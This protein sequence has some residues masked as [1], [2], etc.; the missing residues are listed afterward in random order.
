MVNVDTRRRIALLVVATGTLGLAT[1]PARGDDSRDALDELKQGYSLKQLGNCRDALPHLARSVRLDPS[2]RALLNL[3]DCEQQLG[4]LVEAEGH[5]AQGRELA[6]Q[7]DEAE[8]VTAADGQL[9]SI[10]KRLPRLTIRLAS[11]APPHC[12]VAS[13]GAV[14]EAA[15]LGVEVGVDPGAHVLVVSAPGYAQRRFDVSIEEG[16]RKEVEVEP[17]A[18]L[19]SDASDVA[20]SHPTTAAP[21]APRAVHAST[22]PNRVLAWTVLAVGAAAVTVGVVT[23]LSAG[24]KHTTLAGECDPQGGAC[25][26]GSQGDIDSFHTLRTASTIAY[27]IG[28]AGLVGGAVLW[29]TAPSPRSDAAAHVWLGPAAAG[30]AGRF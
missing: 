25:P 24:S 1:A 23:G 27:A 18:K 28:A 2:E 26:P 6:R 19:Q 11:T 30:I 17:G 12:A 16:A 29:L 13:D 21:A 7:K 5:A 3:S 20:A 15:S 22:S 8:L 4:E 14:I 9:V 10:A